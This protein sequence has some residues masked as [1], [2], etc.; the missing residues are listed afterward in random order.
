VT[1]ATARWRREDG[2]VER[3]LEAWGPVRRVRSLGGGNRNEVVEVELAGRRMVARR[4]RRPA[5]SLAWEI[6]LLE[7]LGRSGVRVPAV[8]PTPDGR[9][10]VSGVL[11]MT[12]LDGRPPAAGDWPA[13]AA[14]LRRVHEL[15]RGWPQ[16]P[17]AASTRALLTADRGGDVDLSVMPAEAVAAC[18]R[19]WAAL[20]GAPEAVVHGDPGPANIRVTDEGIGLL[21]WDEA[22]VDATDLDL[23][24]LPELPGADQP[25]DRLAVARTAAT[26]WEA[27][28]GWTVEPSYARRQLALLLAGRDGFSS[29][30]PG[31]MST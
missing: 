20:A 29:G 23:A 1:R 17:G 18:R 15:T 9:R 5:A 3:V 10:Q 12:W 8:V 13:V 24:E 2:R 6:R 4:S 11:L 26:A 16:R 27:A 25:D 19:A 21:D 28:N 14:T 30:G 22:R 31:S 7:H